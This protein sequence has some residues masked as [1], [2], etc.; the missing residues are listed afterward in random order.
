MRRNRK[1]SPDNACPH[2]AL[3]DIQDVL[4]TG[5]PESYKGRINNAIHV[6]VEVL[7]P[8]KEKKQND[9]LAQLLAES[10]LDKS[11]IKYRIGIMDAID[12]RDQSQIHGDGDHTSKQ[13]QQKQP[14][15]LL[16]IFVLKIDVQ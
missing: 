12:Q 11:G 1:Q 8:P 9:E 3:E 14:E 6:F 5:E 7:V 10:G 15:R 4:H 16:L 2:T 13:G